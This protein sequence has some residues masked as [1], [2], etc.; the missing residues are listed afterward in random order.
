MLCFLTVNFGVLLVTKQ[1]LTGCIISFSQELR[2]L[3][4]SL[5]DPIRLFLKILKEL[6]CV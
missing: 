1:L 2:Q 6:V 5:F 3:Y 4:L